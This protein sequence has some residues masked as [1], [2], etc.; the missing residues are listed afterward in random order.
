MK[1][2]RSP[3]QE[4]PGR[5]QPI[6]ALIGIVFLLVGIL[7]FVPGVTTDYDAMSWAGHHS[8]AQLLGVFEVSALHN[9]VHVLFGVAGLVLARQE[10]TGRT[11][12]VG[13]GGVYLVLFVYGLVVD[14][15]SAANF[16]PVNDADNWL[17]LALGIGMVALGVM[18]NRG[19]DGDRDSRQRP[20]ERDRAGEFPGG[21]DRPADADRDRKPV[22]RAHG[23]SG[24]PAREDLPDRQ[25]GRGRHR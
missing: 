16:V 8:G 1:Q 10:S 4:R 22:G 13:G 18:P 25:R 12:L 21:R 7:G 15:N 5:H 6:A 20:R 23:D 11:Y 14:H 24:R 3:R 19:R 9:I 17:H 2:Q